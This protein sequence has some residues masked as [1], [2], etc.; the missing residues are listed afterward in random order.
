MSFM[1]AMRHIFIGL[2]LMTIQ[3][4]LQEFIMMA[5]SIILERISVIYKLQMIL[6]KCIIS[7]E[8]VLMI[9]GVEL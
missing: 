9:T 2:S 6:I 5:A 8:C 7:Q 4:L 1:V 3:F